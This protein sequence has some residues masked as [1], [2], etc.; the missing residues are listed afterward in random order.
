LNLHQLIVRSVF[1]GFGVLLALCGLAAAGEELAREYQLKAVFLYRFTQFVD[2][3]ASAFPSPES[4]IVIGVL[5]RNPF[6]GY[7]QAAV[8]DERVGRRRM[9][10]QYFQRPQDVRNCQ[11]LFISAS[12]QGHLEKILADLKGQS[13]LTVGE[14]KDFALRGGMI[15]FVTEQNH[16]RFRI[17]LGAARAA[18]LQISSKLLELAEVVDAQ[19]Q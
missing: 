12:E 19:S 6:A 16:I 18:H 5:G 9:L 8:R 1:R 2:W 11:I 10:V 13:I 17:N 14:G 3:P 15:Q 7:L 4:P